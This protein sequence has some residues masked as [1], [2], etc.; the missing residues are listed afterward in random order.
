MADVRVAGTCG[1]LIRSIDWRGSALGP[2]ERWP[3]SLRAMVA[4][5]LHARQPM[6]LFWGPEL[7]QLYNDAFVPSFGHGKHPAAMGQ[8]AR[9]CWQDAWP[10][11]G[12]QIEAV[13]SRGEPAWH[14]DALVPIHRNGRMEEV[15]WTYSYSPAFDDD[16]RIQGTLV[17]VTE[18]TGRVV[19]A[20]RLGGL[21][22][23]GVELAA[24]T[25][26]AA[27]FDGLARAVS[28]RPQDLP[29]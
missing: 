24:A 8:P 14:E 17:I 27:A 13:M 15:F 1:E 18:V 3:A 7:L 9:E 22:A 10:V 19:S 28:G 4:N 6:L 23:L 2:M 29:F 20:R 11:V 21:S 12:A 16:A 5:M 25:D 26:H